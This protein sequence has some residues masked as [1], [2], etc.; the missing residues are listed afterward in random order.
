MGKGFKEYLYT[1]LIGTLYIFSI[2]NAAL[3]S[4]NVPVKPAQL[5]LLSLGAF[6]FYCL[7][8]TR[9]GGIVFMCAAG[10][11]IGYIT[12]SLISGGV[13]RLLQAF[14]PST[15]LINVMIQIGSGYYSES[16]S[17]TMLMWAIS[18]FS[19]IVALP[20]YTFLVRYFRFYPLIVP[21]LIFFMIV[22]GINR[23]VHKLSFYIFIIIAIICFILHKYIQHRK[24]NSLE[25]SVARGSFF[26]YF[27][28]V[29]IIVIIAASVFPV[30]P[31]PIQWP[32][33]DR[34]I[35]DLYWDIHTRLNV[36][37]YDNFSL[38][39]TGFGNPSK[40]GGPVRPDNTPVLLVHAPTRVYLRGAVYDKYSGIGW[41][42]SNINPYEFL[43]DRTLDHDDLIF[44]WKAA[45][46]N[47]GIYS[48]DNFNEYIKSGQMNYYN[49]KTQNDFIEFLLQE[50][51]PPL[52][53]RLHPEKELT[54]R[55]LNVRT[56]TVFT[57]L[58]VLDQITGLHNRYSLQEKYGGVF[59]SERRLPGNSQYK[60]NYLQPAYGMKEL[61]NYYSISG[62]GIYQNFI[63]YLNGFINQ[64]EEYN[65][66]DLENVQSE[67]EKILSIYQKLERHRNE[68]HAIYTQIP[69]SVPERVRHLALDLAGSLASPFEKVR[70][71]EVF[72]R[73]NFSFRY[74]LSPVVPPAGQDFVDFFL[75]D[76]REGYCSYYASALCIMAR[77]L[78][79]PARYV[80]GFV[81]PEYPDENGYYYVTNLNAHAWVEVYLEGVGWVIFE[82]TPPMY[83]AM[84]YTVS[85]SDSSGAGYYDPEMYEDDEGELYLQ[86]GIYIDIELPDYSQVKSTSITVFLSVF[87]IFIIILLMNQVFIFIRNIVLRIMSAKKSV[88]I[89][90]RYIVSLLSQAGCEVLPGETP[91][92]YAARVDSRYRFDIMTMNEMV[93][94]Y[95]HVRFGNRLLDK[96]ELKKLFAFVRDVKTKSADSMY[97]AK[98]FLY[99][100]VLFKG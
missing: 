24:N 81:L 39:R 80:E 76:G 73:D 77:S 40:L 65:I 17:N 50:R 3:F 8:D 36:D 9:V 58:K 5:F 60:I 68:I 29:A 90:Y 34:K 70:A 53:K 42:A 61:D 6:I 44:G 78:G 21:G 71:L 13:S 92:D 49:I 14:A 51:T 59:V 38:D 45:C 93:D 32:W 55:H 62:N 43:N 91:K 84:D 97:I 96:Y 30:N 23:N 19:A 75:F 72:L 7:V 15:K 26:I 33:M 64:L 4:M 2:V 66:P 52:I 10:I 85:L 54:V 99:R 94:L 1:G 83:G 63:V 69:D 79:I 89:L 98:R 47:K 41:E 12:Y 56:K 74:T 20:V 37:R 25:S 67:L 82:P 86:D 57:P 35:N 22:W 46:W 27:F 16:I 11:G 31:L 48:L 95:Y 18:V 100:A 88:P 87:A 28:P